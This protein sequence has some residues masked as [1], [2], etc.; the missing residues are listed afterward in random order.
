[1]ILAKILTREDRIKNQYTKLY[2]L[3]QRL[4]N[5]SECY[6]IAWDGTIH[7]KSLVGFEEI[8]IHLRYPDSIN[9]FTGA[10][11]LPNKFFEFGK[12]AKKT[13][14]TIKET[15]DSFEF[16]QLD[17]EELKFT[18]NII[19]KNSSMDKEYLS[20]MVDPKMYKRYFE[21]TSSKYTQYP[22]E[23]FTMLT[24]KQNEDIINANPVYMT[25]NDANLTLTKHLVLD[26]K[27]GDSLG[28]KR[29]CY[30]KID[31]DNSRVFYM[32]E[33]RAD[34]YDSYTIFNTLQQIT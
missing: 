28:I 7:L 2:D 19:N 10:M 20:G 27:K 14:L 5:I 29:M 13:K 25:F 16:G 33:H 26:I 34:L 30:Q 22:V 12:K 31:E 6:Y 32:I 21:L 18:L 3:N 8:L 9:L 15:E 4:K 1:M 11:I 24:D 23:D 17:D